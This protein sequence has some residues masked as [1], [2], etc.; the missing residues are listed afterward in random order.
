MAMVP[1][2]TTQCRNPSKIPSAATKPN[3]SKKKK[4][5]KYHCEV[6][7]IKFRQKRRVGNGIYAMREI[8]QH[9]K[10][11]REFHP[12]LLPLFVS[13]FLLVN[14]YSVSDLISFIAHCRESRNTVS[15]RNAFCFVVMLRLWPMPILALQFGS[16]RRMHSLLLY[17]RPF[18]FPIFTSFFLTYLT[19]KNVF[20]CSK[21]VTWFLLKM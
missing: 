17:N 7:I 14:V 1:S 3:Q 8:L 21:F 16:V 6:L 11:H 19:D 9:S 18:N 4:K 15:A 5:K 12:F 10:Q 2:A 20:T 13:R